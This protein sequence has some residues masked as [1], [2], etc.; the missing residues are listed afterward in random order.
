MF[1][2]CLFRCLLRAFIL[3]RRASRDFDPAQAFLPRVAVLT[4]LSEEVDLVLVD[5]VWAGDLLGALVRHVHRAMP[6]A[7]VVGFFSPS[8]EDAL[9]G[10]LP[11]PRERHAW[12]KLP[13]VL[14]HWLAGRRPVA[15]R[16]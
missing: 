16:M 14:T 7:D 11:P 12:E 15:V 9:R 4:L 3:R 10:Y 5:V 1:M 2:R 6:Q 13:A 8:G